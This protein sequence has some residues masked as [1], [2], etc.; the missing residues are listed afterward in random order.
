MKYYYNNKLLLTILSLASVG[1]GQIFS[2]NFDDG[3]WSDVWTLNDTSSYSIQFIDGANDSEYGLKITGG[4]NNGHYDGLSATFDASQPAYIGYY[5]KP[6]IT[7]AINTNYLVIKDGTG[8]GGNSLIFFLIGDEEACDST[9]SFILY[10]DDW[11]CG[12]PV[13]SGEWHHIEYRNIDF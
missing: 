2:D 5:V 12:P 4:A 7:R 1:F 3:V 9:L 11:L 8:T 6:Q 10:A 13:T